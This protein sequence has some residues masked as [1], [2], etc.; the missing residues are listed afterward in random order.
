MRRGFSRR[1]MTTGPQ[2]PK[3]VWRGVVVLDN[4]LAFPMIFST[5]SEQFL[6]PCSREL[7]SLI[8][9]LNRNTTA[10]RPVQHHVTPTFGVHK[11]GEPKPRLRGTH[12]RVPRE[13]GSARRYS[14]RGSRECA[15]N[16][17]GEHKAIKLRGR[18]AVTA[19]GFELAQS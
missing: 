9:K 12:G 10:G 2:V 17:R 15:R 3:S 8:A 19:V 18:K 14:T 13:S 16:L 6:P 1:A 7:T 11:E 5:S 4:T